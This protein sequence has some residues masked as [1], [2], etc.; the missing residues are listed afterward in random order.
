MSKF[1]GDIVNWVDNENDNFSHKTHY[2]GSSITKIEFG[3]KIT[4]YKF[5]RQHDHQRGE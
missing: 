5:D 1:D 4:N 2:D 3:K